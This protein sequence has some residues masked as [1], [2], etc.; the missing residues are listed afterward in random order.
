MPLALPVLWA[1]L[2]QSE[3]PDLFFFSLLSSPN[4]R[5]MPESTQ[6]GR[7]RGTQY[8]VIALPLIGDRRGDEAMSFRA[9]SLPLPVAIAWLDLG[10]RV[11]C[12]LL[13]N[14][15]TFL[16]RLRLL[17][18]QRF[19]LTFG[20]GILVSRHEHSIWPLKPKTVVRQ[21]SADR[22]RRGGIRTVTPGL[23]QATEQ[24]SRQQSK[25]ISR[26]PRGIR[27]R[28]PTCDLGAKD[29]EGSRGVSGPFPTMR[30]IARWV[31]VG[32][33]DWILCRK[34]T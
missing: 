15:A 34:T 1:C 27:G 4:F 33:P 14:P 31:P 30:I 9:Q 19:P 21:N 24:L 10:V 7:P 11:A 3:I 5:K 32:Q 8:Q 29:L 16:L 26:D 6:G 25:R 12:P 13:A 28:S 18:L 22:L 20:V 23:G 17:P 2:V